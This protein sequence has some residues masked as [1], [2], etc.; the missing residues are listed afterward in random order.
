MLDAIITIFSFFG[1]TWAI[2]NSDL[3]SKPRNWIMRQ[4]VFLF[5]LFSCP[6]CL[7]FHVGWIIYLIHEKEW[8]WNLFILWGL[9]SAAISFIISTIINRLSI[10]KL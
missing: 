7:G 5:E 8:H 1:L 6:F 9:A 2:Q 3:L 10:V 4:S